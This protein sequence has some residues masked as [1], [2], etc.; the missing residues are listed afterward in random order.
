MYSHIK[1]INP[2]LISFGWSHFTYI[3]QFFGDLEVR[4]II[5]TVF[6]RATRSFGH[7]DDE[8]F[9]FHH[10]VV[11]AGTGTPIC[12]IGE[13]VQDTDVNENDNLCATYSIMAYF[14]IPFSTDPV[15]NQ[16]R[17]VRICERLINNTRFVAAINAAI[18]TDPQE[19]TRWEIFRAGSGSATS[20][21]SPGSTGRVHHVNME[22][23][24]FWRKIRTTM[25]DWE[26]YGHLYF[27]GD[28]K[29][30]G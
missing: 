18:L 14:G 17:M 3:N 11:D 12:S 9:G 27:I 20:A 25:N 6:P 29:Y 10:Y 13:G 1:A 2:K 7:Y 8:E 28:G 21:G 30:H 19:T 24:A 15:T 4:D 16:I 22:P 5:E 26:N 23:V